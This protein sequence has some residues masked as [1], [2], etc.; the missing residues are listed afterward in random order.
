MSAPNPPHA[1]SPL[2]THSIEQLTSQA[3][4]AAQ[5]G[6][7]DRVDACYTARG[8]SLATGVVD[9]AVAERLLTMDEQVRA[10]I[11]VAQAGISAQL[12]DAAQVTRHLRR[13][14]ESGGRL[15]PEQSTMHHEI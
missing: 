9:R 4:E 12:A 14:R 15:V 1:R 13:L 3:I 8:I 11:L 2:D 7:W 5:A 10:A 6:D